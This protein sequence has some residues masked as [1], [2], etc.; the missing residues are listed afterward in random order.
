MGIALLSALL[1]DASVIVAS[2]G[3][4]HFSVQE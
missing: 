1:L 3:T 2:G 4:T